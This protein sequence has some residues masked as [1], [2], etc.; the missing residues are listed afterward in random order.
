[1][2]NA[3][4]NPVINSESS[5]ISNLADTLVARVDFGKSFNINADYIGVDGLIQWKGI[6]TMMQKS[7]WNYV[8]FH[9]DTAFVASSDITDKKVT[10][11]LFFAVKAVINAIG[12]VNG[13]ELRE[14]NAIFNCAVKVMERMSDE[15][16]GEALTVKSELANVNKELRNVK[17]GMSEEYVTALETKKEVL[18]EQLKELKKVKGMVTVGH[19]K[20]N[21]NTFRRNF[22]ASL[23]K[24][25]A[26]QSRKS[27][28]ELQAEEEARKAEKRAAKKAARKNS[29]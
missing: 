18:S 28:D 25:V 3:N 26:G 8:K 5:I 16:H 19:N 1:M 23:A 24:I 22:E 20:V 14:N 6:C 17:N 15:Y 29:K 13:F 12:P 7:A 10:D 27:F 9:E 2:K 21:E 4:L 11:D